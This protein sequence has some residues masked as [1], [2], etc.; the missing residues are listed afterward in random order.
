MITGI[1]YVTLCS[2]WL[3]R[4]INGA[5]S[6]LPIRGTFETLEQCQYEATLAAKWVIGDDYRWR[7][8]C[9]K[10]DA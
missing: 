6:A 10:G 4:L 2:G 7:V 9:K 5:E 1:V 3:C 8:E